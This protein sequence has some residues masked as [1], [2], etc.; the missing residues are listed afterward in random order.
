MGVCGSEARSTEQR[1]GIKERRTLKIDLKCI[2]KTNSSLAHVN[3]LSQ[4]YYGKLPEILEMLFECVLQPIPPSFDD[5][6]Q[7]HVLVVK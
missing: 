7:H 3:P 2:L 5:Y 6:V 4:I 1:N